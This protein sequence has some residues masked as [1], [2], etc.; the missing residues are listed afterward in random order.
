VVSFR[1]RDL[2]GTDDSIPRK[3]N[4][5]AVIPDFEDK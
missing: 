4:R 5:P 1:L 2:S 3:S